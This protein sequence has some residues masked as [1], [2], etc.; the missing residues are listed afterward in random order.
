MSTV[1]TSYVEDNISQHFFSFSGSYT[2]FALASVMFSELW[3]VRQ[4]GVD[5][6]F[7]AWHSQSFTLSPF[8]TL[9]TAYGKKKLL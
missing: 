4:V 5:V 3:R 6:P 9:T 8:P 2:V 7:S 1:A